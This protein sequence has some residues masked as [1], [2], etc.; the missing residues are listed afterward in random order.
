MKLSAAYSVDFLKAQ[1]HKRTPVAVELQDLLKEIGIYRRQGRPRGS[2]AGRK[3]LKPIPTITGYRPSNF[4][5]RKAPFI[6]VSNLIKIKQSPR[7]AERSRLPVVYLT[8]PRSLVNKLDELQATL[9]TN[10]VDIAA[11]SE[12]WFTQDHPEELL[13]IDGFIHYSKRRSECRGGG[14]SVYIKDDIPSRQLSNITVPEELEC[15]WIW[16]RPHQLPRL[17]S[18]VIICC[19]YLP[20]QSPHQNT[21]REH[22]TTATDR[23]RTEHPNCGIVLLGDFNRFDYSS[24][25]RGNGFKQVVK[26]G[27]RGDVTLDLIITDMA[28]LYDKPTILPPLGLSDHQAILWTP[29]GVRSN[30]TCQ[31]HQRRLMKPAN[32]YSFG[33]WITSHPWQEVYDAKDVTSKTSAFYSTLSAACNNHFPVVTVK[34]HPTDRPWMTTEIKELIVRRQRAHLKGRTSLLARFYRNKVQQAIKKAKQ[35]FFVSKISKLKKE[36]PRLWH[37]EVQTMAGMKKAP[38]RLHVEG[39]ESNDSAGIANE[40]N[41]RLSMVSQ[42]LLPLDRA[43]LPAFLPAPQPLPKIQHWEVYD[44]LRQVKTNKAGGPDDI[45]QRVLK[46]FACELS[47]PV[48]DIL[49]ESFHQGEFPPQWKEATVVPIPKCNPPSIEQI[50]PISLTP[51]LAKIA[52]HFASE[53]IKQ[54]ITSNLDPLQFGSRPDRSATQALV[55]ILDYLYKQSDIPS[56]C[57][58]LITTDFSKAFDKVDHTIAME[59][60]LQLG[61]RPALVT[62]VGSFM[63]E[64]RQRVRYQDTVSDW[65]EMTGGVAQGTLLGPLIFLALIDSA[66]RDADNRWKYVDDLNLAHSCKNNNWS[67]PQAIL[68]SFDEWVQSSKMSLNPT[69]CKV[70]SITFQRNPPTPSLLQIQGQVLQFCDSVKILGLTVQKDLQWG[71]QVNSM[72]K[73][74][75]KKLFFLRR[76]KRSNI[77]RQDLV[78]I[79]SGYLRPCLEYATPAWHGSLNQVQTKDLE[80]VQKRACRIILGREYDGY[81]KALQTLSLSS[82]QDRRTKL[83]MDF[84][85]SLLTSQFRSWLPP[86]RAEATGKHSRSS[87]KLVVPRARTD[88]YKSSPIPFLT[89]LINN[90]RL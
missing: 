70:L 55:S 86:T 8:N 54:D 57:T 74:G 82:L 77:P 49:N 42:S 5:L 15:V 69:K 26:V 47:Q 13:S 32:M 85:K 89:S 75:N 56:T 21:F 43:A 12:S 18:A 53:W 87:N 81:E 68:D 30:N 33:Q 84:A 65:Q 64:R 48:C 23:L 2:K 20:P 10:R 44:K 24:I 60:L 63:S 58:T 76:L 35:T 27:T 45:P 40:I 90:T 61:L 28:Q 22:L 6:H 62:W 41:N 39:Y 14:V 78:A 7:P 80:R 50:R 9:L 16:A 36:N 83:C 59:R 37:R 29:K 1:R 19:V 46:E 51:Q 38:L 3:S 25:G 71:E 73:K 79:Y 34:L 4:V 67:S 88:R 72:I 11:I 31:K 17:F 52:E 66:A